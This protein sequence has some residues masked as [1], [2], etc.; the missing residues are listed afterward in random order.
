MVENQQR[1]SDLRPSCARL[2]CL[3]CRSEVTCQGEGSEQEEGEAIRR[4][5]RKALML[6]GGEEEQD[7]EEEIDRADGTGE[8]D[9]GLKSNFSFLEFSYFPLFSERSG[10]D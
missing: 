5:M 1:K 9:N 3:R 2:Q 7:E 6:T 8:W 4:R 10:P